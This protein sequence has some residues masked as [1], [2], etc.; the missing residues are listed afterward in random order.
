[1]VKYLPTSE[2]TRFL[3]IV[4]GEGKDMEQVWSMYDVEQCIWI[5][6]ETC[7]ASQ[8][9]LTCPCA[10]YEIHCDRFLRLFCFP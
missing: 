4:S 9:V 1:M 2:R 6:L 8:P 10:S 7:I 3:M 5:V